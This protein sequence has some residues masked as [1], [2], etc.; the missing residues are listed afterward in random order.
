MKR[1]FFSLFF[2]FTAFAAN[3]Q[4]ADNP[5]FWSALKQPSSIVLFRHSNA[6][7][8]GDPA[9]FRANDCS[10]QRN[11]DKEGREQATRIGQRF[12]EQGIKVEAVLSSQW[13]RT[14][15]TAQLAFPN[16]Q[17]M[18]RCLI[19]FSEIQTMNPSKQRHRVSY[20]WIGKARARWWW[21]RIKSISPN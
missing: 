1:I 3:A 19:R 17:K 11:L 7:G 8:G 20:C 6:P 2:A 5:E 21:L 13:C 14:R 16:M 4:T 10:T 15:E 18:P 12:R 9:G